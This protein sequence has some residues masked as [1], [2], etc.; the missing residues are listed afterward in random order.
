MLTAKLL[1]FSSC[2]HSRGGTWLEGRGKGEGCVRRENMYWQ[3]QVQECR[4]SKGGIVWHGE[5]VG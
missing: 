3:F 5:R 2:R 1:D 4:A